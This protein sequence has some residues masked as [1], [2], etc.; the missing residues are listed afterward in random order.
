MEL[1]SLLA[2]LT[3]D[4]NEFDKDL[5]DAQRKAEDFDNITPALELDSTDFDQ[6]IVESQGLGNT[7]G[8][9]MEGVFKGIKN[10]LTV[11]GIVAAI[12]GI[13]S[14]LKE[15]VNMTAETA[16]GIDK[17]SKR[18]NISTKNYQAW[19]H[20]LRQSGASINDL[21]KGV[22]LM[23]N[24][25][26]GDKS[27]EMGK[28]FEQLGIDADEAGE[29]TEKLIEKTL[30][31]LAGFTGTKDERGILVN[32][33]F[34]KG[35][36]ALN[37]FLDEGEEGVKKLLGE[38][39]GLGLIMSDDEIKNAVAYGDAV[40]N[41][42]EELNAIR[43]AFVAD[44]IPVLK[45]ATE[46]LTSLLQTFNPRARENALVDTFKKIDEQTLTSINDLTE[47]EAKA[48]AIIDKLA[49]MGDYWT[50]DD[51]GKKTFDTLADELIRLYP[52]LDKVI[53]NNGKAIADNKQEI[54]KNIDAWTLLEKQRILDQN[55]ADK[56]TAIAEKYAKA[57]DKEIEA[58]DKEAEA[59]GKRAVAIGKLND[60]LVENG[61]SKISENA[62]SEEVT[63]A[64]D[65]LTEGLDD[66]DPLRLT[67]GLLFKEYGEAW[68]QAAKLREES[69]KMTEEADKA[70]KELT[71]YS[72]K[73]AE[74]MGITTESVTETEEQVAELN[75]AL[76]GIPDD[77]YTTVH[78]TE[79]YLGGNA[80]L[81]GK[82]IGDRYVP[83]DNYPALLH[84]GEKVL[85]ATEARQ[86]TKQIDY[87]ELE[88]RIIKAI[89]AGME[90]VEVNSYLDGSLVTDK[91]S[92]RLADQLADRRYV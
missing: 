89:K 80:H 4:S 91:V 40:A 77:V 18:L 24:Y 60:L 46:W 70:Q 74:K 20:A 66:E 56:R 52:E 11:T 9:E 29:S 22:L 65:R 7:F 58:E 42:N 79:D 50:L 76:Q 14:G 62:T 34:G 13:V 75:K 31:A 19:D 10:A 8:T 2:K 28:A 86:D 5:N 1:F 83:Y 63:Q 57:L 35:G 61:F 27:E 33:L 23:N 41:L 71:T 36:T 68:T 82:A 45:D 21:Q 26:N 69:N 15:A 92:K 67:V 49:E 72:E 48:K 54:L 88:D 25:L 12:S 51:N 53:A 6:N 78:I 90:D 43:S 32:T 87:T 64:M 17:G 30:M 38:A 47:K 73:L 84:R 59:A 55:V 16:D 3:L 85:T 39:E 37:A 81:P 44:I